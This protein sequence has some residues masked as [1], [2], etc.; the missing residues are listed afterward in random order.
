L[1]W[2]NFPLSTRNYHETNPHIAQKKL[3]KFHE[4][5]KVTVSQTQPEHSRSI[6]MNRLETWEISARTFNDSQQIL[7][8]LSI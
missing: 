4:N 3:T 6:E 5:V 1:G 7:L 2:R 8:Q